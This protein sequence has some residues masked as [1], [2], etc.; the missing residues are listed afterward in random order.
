[1]ALTLTNHIVQL[2]A[3]AWVQPAGLYVFLRVGHDVYRGI[4]SRRKHNV[5][6]KHLNLGRVLT[7]T[8]YRAKAAG[9]LATASLDTNKEAKGQWEIAYNEY[10]TMMINPWRGSMAIDFD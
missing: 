6:R 4:Q 8:R 2:S 3:I 7:K 1:M 10:S 9:K 5:T